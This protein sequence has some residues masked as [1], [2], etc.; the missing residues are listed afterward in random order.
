MFIAAFVAVS[1]Q[2]EQVTDIVT[3]HERALIIIPPDGPERVYNIETVFQSGSSSGS[4]LNLRYYFYKEHFDRLYNPVHTGEA[5]P[6]VYI[7]GP[8]ELKEGETLDRL[9]EIYDDFVFP[10]FVENIVI[11]DLDESLGLG[12]ELSIPMRDGV[13]R[14]GNNLIDYVKI[15]SFVPS[16]TNHPVL[17]DQYSD[18]N[19]YIRCKSGTVI[20]IRYINGETY[21]LFIGWGSS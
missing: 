15:N 7:S 9:L 18:M 12:R 1:C 11:N 21:P 4:S 20:S 17:P 16:Q 6:I 5:T 3:S 2:K 10:R 13:Y 19:I 14:G 8:Y